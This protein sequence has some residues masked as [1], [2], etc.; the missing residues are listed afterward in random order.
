MFF[1]LPTVGSLVDTWAYLALYL[2]G[3][4]SLRPGS[5]PLAVYSSTTVYIYTPVEQKQDKKHENDPIET[6]R[7][8]SGFSRAG[9]VTQPV[10]AYKNALGDLSE[11][12]QWNHI[13]K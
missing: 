5:S 12:T 11:P 8:F 2:G 3:T 13:L 4:P 10:G 7:E 9:Q 1:L 6:T